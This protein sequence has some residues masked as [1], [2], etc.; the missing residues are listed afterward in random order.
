MLIALTVRNRYLLRFSDSFEQ[1][2]YR[3]VL[4]YIEGKSYD[5]K[6]GLG[7]MSVSVLVTDGLKY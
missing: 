3:H 6:F 7:N 4:S 1:K 2:Y 5:N